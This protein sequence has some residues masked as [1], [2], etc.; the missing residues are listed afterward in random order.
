MSPYKQTGLHYALMF[1]FLYCNCLLSTVIHCIL[2]HTVLQHPCHVHLRGTFQMWKTSSQH[3]HN[4]NFSSSRTTVKHLKW[5]LKVW[6][7]FIVMFS[8]ITSQAY[9]FILI[10]W[11]SDGTAEQEQP[12]QCFFMPHFNSLS[13]S[14]I[15]ASVLGLGISQ[16]ALRKDTHGFYVQREEDRVPVNHH[17]SS[18]SHH[19]TW[20][21]VIKTHLP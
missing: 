20:N 10:R 7:R 2:I 13:L 9:S 19:S 15:F 3:L 5:L 8:Y 4:L 14:V 17:T 6:Y 12:F 16:L 1:L 21:S 18:S 11:R